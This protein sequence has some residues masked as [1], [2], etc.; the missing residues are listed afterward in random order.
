MPVSF[1]LLM[2]LSFAQQKIYGTDDLDAVLILGQI[3][4]HGNDDFLIVARNILQGGT[5]P[6]LWFR[7]RSW[8]R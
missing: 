3:T 4:F 6:V 8:I 5:A 7:E 2:G 1:S